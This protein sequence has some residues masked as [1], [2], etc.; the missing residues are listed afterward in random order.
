M[1][2]ITTKEANGSF[3]DQLV[4]GSVGTSRKWFSL[5]KNILDGS[6]HPIPA[7]G[8]EQVG[9]IGAH[10]SDENGNILRPVLS[11]DGVDDYV[12]CDGNFTSIISE[13]T[14][15]LWMKTSDTLNNGTPLSYA[16]THSDNEIL[17]YRYNGF[18]LCIGG[19][20]VF[21]NI[22]VNDGIWHHIAWTWKS[23]GGETKLFK[24]G[25][26]VYNGTL[27]SGYTINHGTSNALILGQ[28]QDSV[29]GGFDPNQAFLGLLREVRIWN[30]ARTQEEIKRDMNKPLSGN[31]SGLVGYWTMDE[32]SGNTVYDKTANG[33]HGTVYG[34][35]WTTTQAPTVVRWQLDSPR[36]IHTLRVAGDS[37]VGAYPVDFDIQLYS[38]SGNLLYEENVTN[39]K[40]IGNFSRA[41]KAYKS[42]GTEVGNNVPRFEEGKFGQAVMVEEG[43]TN[44]IG[45]PSVEVSLSGYFPQDL[46]GSASI[47]RVEAENGVVPYHGDYMVKLITTGGSGDVL[48][49][50]SGWAV[51][52]TITFSAWVMP[53]DTSMCRLF[54]TYYDGA[55]HAVASN[56]ALQGVEQ[57]LS[58]TFE[59]PDNVTMIQLKVQIDEAGTVYT[60]AWQL[61][62]KPYAT[63]FT[64]GTRSAETLAIPTEGILNPQEG[65]VEWWSYIGPTQRRQGAGWPVLFA[66]Q[67]VVAGKGI[68]LFHSDNSAE[69]KVFVRNETGQ[70][71]SGAC[72]DSYTPD[73]WHQFALVWNA[74]AVKLLID[75]IVR[76]TISNPTLP[77]AFGTVAYVGRTVA[78]DFA[79]TLHDDLRIS[80]RARTDEEIAAAYASGEPLPVDEHTTSK[81][82]F[83][84]VW[85]KHLL[86]VY[87]ASVMDISI[88]KVSTASTPSVRLTEV[89]NPFEVHRGD[90]V[91]PK[92][93]DSTLLVGVAV[94]SADNLLP[95]IAEQ[96]EIIVNFTKTDTLLPRI[97]DSSFFT[98]YE[99][100]RDDFLTPRTEEESFGITAS[101]SK[102]D[103]LLP[104]VSEAKQIQVS[105]SKTDTLLPKVSKIRQIQAYFTKQDTLLPKAIETDKAIT[106]S[107]SKVDTLLPK[108]SKTKQIQV[109]FSKTDTLLP[110]VS[111]SKHITVFSWKE[112]ELVLNPYVEFEQITVYLT[113]PDNL[114]LL[115][116]LAELSTPT[117]VY[118]R[119]NEAERRIYGKV[120]IVY[121]NPLLDPTMVI[122]ATEQGR[123]TDPD[124]TADNVITPKYK[125]FSLHDNKLDGSYHPLP[126]DK[127]PSV[128]WWGQTLSDVNGDFSVPP[129][130]TITFG[131]ARPVTKLQLAGD[132]LLNSYPVD[133]DIE[134][135]DASDVRVYL[136]EVRGNTLAV[137]SKDIGVVANVKRMVFKIYKINKAHQPVKIVE[138]YTNVIEVYEGT[139]RLKS[140]HLLEELAYPGTGGLLGEVTANEIDIAL[141]NEDRH[142]TP[143]NIDS[144]VNGLL[145][146]NRRVRVWLGVEI[147]P[148]EIEWYPL[149]VFWTVAWRV[150]N[151]EPWA[152]ATARDRLELLRQSEFATS[153]V[154]V[155]YSIYDLAEVILQDAGLTTEEYIIDATLQDIVIPYAWFDR[156]SHRAALQRLAGTGLIQVYC[157]R[158]GRVRV[159]KTQP[160][161]TVIQTF[162]D[163]TNLFDKDFPLAWGQVANYVEV[164]ATPWVE[165][166]PTTLCDVNETITVPAEQT[167]DVTLTFSTIPAVNVQAPIITGDP[168]IT[169]ENYVAY[170]WGI[171]ITLRNSGAS[172]EQVTRIQV[173]GTPLQQASQAVVSVWN[174]ASIRETGKIKIGIQ[175]DFIQTRTY[176][177][178]LA[179]ELLQFSLAAKHDAVLKTRGDIALRLGDRVTAPSLQVGGEADY[180]VKK[181]ELTW[182]GYLEETIEGQKITE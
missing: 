150:P 76:I 40:V 181:Q 172:D 43:T 73:G 74:S 14:I 147:I 149:G 16:T 136:E 110:K 56:Y 11:F 103:T 176:A 46:G 129:E 81:L 163:D 142:F 84:P 21:T 173:D 174:D 138:A 126:A 177:Q 37:N 63:S 94:S 108:V 30:Y 137:W 68:W 93:V 167:V 162:S 22:A 125:W 10:T 62:V 23:S 49:N 83:D 106:A 133:F 105:F 146:M 165:G 100:R 59:I 145:K 104:K 67:E 54:I 7:D 117:N 164:T 120:E 34:A 111:E 116:S 160:T 121:T 139:D 179:E 75:G 60:D 97:V 95:A 144:S 85:K 18:E 119:M 47:N 86:Q 20:T 44:L 90:T 98:W 55:W 102:A 87:E 131:E 2:V 5:Q 80:S 71:T 69:W 155:D 107:F 65:T 135:Y 64:D 88:H 114:N 124:Q 61:E 6:F 96:K 42:D 122:T 27:Q 77:G 17:L 156:V 141:K 35:T 48:Y 123:Y 4:D 32:G 31:E 92:V 19:T 134:L 115:A 28:E 127:W 118:T 33:N 78:G 82:S 50:P 99:F 101:F 112:D 26:L 168:N 91:L 140:I 72:S 36:P 66:I 13:F 1:T 169:V 58:L 182:A 159:E 52:D 143:G 57:R 39:N 152:Y 9:F 132:T 175:H 113:R 158:L 8:S 3:K 128:G 178:S 45:N 151:S 53:Y 154:Y 166:D 157:D 70:T 161:A 171:V 12:N 153:Q 79:N 170:A 109:S 148:G 51:G 15:E 41:S 89:S 29:G 25:N 24:D 38:D 180:M 130:L